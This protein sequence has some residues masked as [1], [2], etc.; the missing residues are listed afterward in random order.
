MIG[1]SPAD[2]VTETPE[3]PAR[4]PAVAR[5]EADVAEARERVAESMRALRDVVARK[6]DWRGWVRRNPGWALGAAFAV[7]VLLGTRGR[8]RRPQNETGGRSRT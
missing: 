6:T 7:G 2:A 5:A 4:D 3:R 8:G 1:R